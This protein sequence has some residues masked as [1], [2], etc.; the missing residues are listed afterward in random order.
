MGTIKENFG[1]GGS[2]LDVKDR[3]GGSTAIH[4][5]DVA[6]DFAELRTQFI[7]LLVKLDADVGINDV[8]YESTLTPAALLT[9]KG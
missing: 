8:N 5:R 7:A 6:D 4:L 9:I 1:S 3:D 2:G